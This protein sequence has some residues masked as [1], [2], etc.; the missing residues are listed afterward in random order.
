MNP[1][2]KA[3][4]SSMTLTFDVTKIMKD[5]VLS[6]GNHCIKFGNYQAKILSKIPTTVEYQQFDIDLC[7]YNLKT[8]RDLLKGNHCTKFVSF[9]TKKS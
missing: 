4:S 1:I 8:N 9:Q 7:I 2:I 5:F 3:T 6:R